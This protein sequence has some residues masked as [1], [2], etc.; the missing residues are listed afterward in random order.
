[1]NSLENGIVIMFCD[2]RLDWQV[3]Y[4]FFSHI[5]RPTL[6]SRDPMAKWIAFSPR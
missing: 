2:A 4:G 3:I 5:V 6:D 1:M